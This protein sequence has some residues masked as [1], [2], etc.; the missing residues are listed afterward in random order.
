MHTETTTIGVRDVRTGHR[1]D[2]PKATTV[3]RVPYDALVLDGPA[4]I[5]GGALYYEK[6]G[7]KLEGRA[8]GAPLGDCHPGERVLVEG[9]LLAAT[10]PGFWLCE[11][12]D[13]NGSDIP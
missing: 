13:V 10:E 7:M 12:E 3:Y 6:R 1:A 5:D 2:L 9:A 4:R 11:V 8:A